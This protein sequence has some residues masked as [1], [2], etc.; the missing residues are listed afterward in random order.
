MNNILQI[1]GHFDKT[2]LIG[3]A[4]LR[5]L[6]DKKYGD[7]NYGI[8]I[9]KRLDD[10]IIDS[11]CDGPTLEYYEYYNHINDELAFKALEVKAA[12]QKNG[13]DS[14][15]IKPTVSTSTIESG[16]ASKNLTFDLSHKMVVFSGLFRI[17][18]FH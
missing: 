6:I 17:K 9:G 11:I 2:Y 4:D 15:I 13:V 14:I 5:G 12:L 16:D 10:R 3:T 18:A 8:S 7:F 1:S